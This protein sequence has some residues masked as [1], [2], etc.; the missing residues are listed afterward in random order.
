MPGDAEVHSASVPESHPAGP[1][2]EN[3]ETEAVGKQPG[4][5]IPVTLHGPVQGMALSPLIWGSS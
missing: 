3:P 5:N 1:W 2:P 4:K